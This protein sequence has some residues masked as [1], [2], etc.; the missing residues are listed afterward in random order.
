MKKLFTIFLVL[1]L[2]VMLAACGGGS[3]GSTYGSSTKT[4]DTC[5]YTY[6]DGTVCG[7]ACNKYSGLCDY[8]FEQ[9]DKT[10]H[11]ILGE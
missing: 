5:T 2:T 8:H 6:S 11:D 9:L 3:S 4:S 7:A 1:V 10:Y